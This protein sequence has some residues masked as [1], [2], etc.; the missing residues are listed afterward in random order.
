MSISTNSKIKQNGDR[1]YDRDLVTNIR[2]NFDYTNIEAKDNYGY[3]K[4]ITDN[5]DD[6]RDDPWNRQDIVTNSK[7]SSEET[8]T[9]GYQNNHTKFTDKGKIIIN[10]G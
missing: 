7:Q 4:D 3:T 6:Q 9:Q 10:D 2:D 5:N 1:Y 8:V